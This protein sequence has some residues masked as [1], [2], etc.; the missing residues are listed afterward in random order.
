MKL[1]LLSNSTNAG[2]PYLGWPRPQIQS[3]L[4][5][6]VKSVLFIP[7]A[8]VS[9]TYDRYLGMVSEALGSIGYGVTSI[10][11]AGE[12]KSAVREAEAIVIGGGNS[13]H[14]LYHLYSEDVV[15]EIRTRVTG[16]IPYIGWS[17][18]ANVSCPTIRTTNDMPIIEPPSL[19]A[20]NLV[21]FQI[22][23]HYIDTHPP[24]HA[25]ETRDQRLAEFI[26][27]NRNTTVVGLREGT[28]IKVEA[29]DIELIGEKAARIF[30]YGQD[31]IDTATLSE[32]L[33]A[34]IA[35][36]K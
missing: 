20:L 22:N 10:H 29:G 26:Q 35:G 34:D 7:F 24:G 16:R 32:Y 8:A 9:Y 23:P 5:D 19:D 21:P 28:M 33:G 6:R 14:L 25:G 4:G 2:E 27:V 12:P 36:M 1:L 17:A 30:R 18:G 11:D 3:F 15:E 31:A 13:F